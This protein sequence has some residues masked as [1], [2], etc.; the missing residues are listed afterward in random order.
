MLLVAGAVLLM[1]QFE[2]VAAPRARAR[3]LEQCEER[4]QKLQDQ[5][6]TA[7]APQTMVAESESLALSKAKHYGTLARERWDRSKA[8]LQVLSR[9]LLIAE[10]GPQQP[11]VVA[12][13]VQLPGEPTEGIIR[14]EMAPDEL[15]PATVLY[16][17]R[18]V[19]EGILNGAVFHRN[20]GHVVQAGPGPNHHM[21]S[22]L[23]TGSS[24][25]FQEYTPKYP[26]KPFTVGLAGRPV[27]TYYMHERSFLHPV[28]LYCY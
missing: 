4:V 6:A 10:F 12:L 17:L 27:R 20:A 16:F 5:V 13:R 9:D 7:A 25:P 1:L 3:A 26:H 15:M 21:L 8:A 18:Q 23:G 14:I 19:R 2:F 11:R 28:S 24:M 22:N